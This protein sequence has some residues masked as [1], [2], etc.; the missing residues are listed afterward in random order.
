MV[1]EHELPR[2]EALRRLKTK[3]GSR[4]AARYRR[5]VI[6]LHEGWADGT[7]SFF[8][9]FKAVGMKVSGTLTVDDSTV[10]VAATFHSRVQAS[11]DDERDHARRR[12]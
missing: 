8:F 9:R 2:D 1:A 5:Q 4:V 11:L 10:R 6:E 3:L 12:P 7:F